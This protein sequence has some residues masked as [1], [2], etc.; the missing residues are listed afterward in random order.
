MKRWIAIGD[1]F[2]YLNDH[3]NETGGRI[4]K[5]YLDRIL[6]QVPDLELFNMGIN[7][8]TTMLWLA[9]NIPKAD[10]YTVILGTND[11]RQLVPIGTVDDMRE[12]VPGT[13]LGNLGV[14][15]KR[16]RT[17]SP[18]ARIIV[19]TPVERGDFV[20]INDPNNNA[21]NSA[22]PE[23]NG[24]YLREIAA[25]I[26]EACQALDIECVDLHEESGFTVENVVRFKHVKTPDGYRDLPWPDYAEYPFD[27][28][29]EYPY[30]AE[31]IG[32]T[33]D[34]LHPSDEGNQRIADLLAERILEQK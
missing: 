3:P 28:A 12:A 32:L 2:T 17:A 18:C 15:I 10:L 7:G 11:W 31:A 4:T 29:D 34:G 27:P 9:V 26:R 20:Y 25:A 30:P 33:Y 1:S 6:E 8:S 16:M 24:V 14:L 19:C 21:H 5:G 13:I 23:E 22:L